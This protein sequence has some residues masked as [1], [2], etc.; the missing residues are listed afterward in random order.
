MLINI[1]MYSH[2]YK[3]AKYWEVLRAVSHE[4]DPLHVPES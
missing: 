3:T 1:Y 4:A 2:A